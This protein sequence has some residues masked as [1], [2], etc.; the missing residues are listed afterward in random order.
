MR[1]ISLS[2]NSKFHFCFVQISG[3]K[4]RHQSLILVVPNL[5]TAIFLLSSLVLFV[6][7]PAQLYLQMMRGN[8]KFTYTHVLLL[9]LKFLINFKYSSQPRLAFSFVYV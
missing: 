7:V 6:I 4:V 5:Y 9:S 8:S 3:D 2:H 1:P